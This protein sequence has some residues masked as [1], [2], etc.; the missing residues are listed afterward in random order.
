VRLLVSGSTAIVRRLAPRWPGVLGHLLTPAN[1]NSVASLLATGLPWGADNGAFGGFDPVRFRRFLRRIR[2]QPR[3]LW[4]VAPDAV[5][6]ARRTLALWREWRDEVRAAGQPVAFVGQDGAEDL[7][8]PWGEFDAWFVGGSTRW[9]LSQAAADL[10]GQAGRRGKWVHMGRCNSRR[11]L[12]AA[13]D[14][15]CDSVDGSSISMF[16]DKYIHQFCLWARQLGEQKTFWGEHGHSGG[17]CRG[18]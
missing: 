17:G 13:Y 15:G 9:K 10:D 2:G 6:D 1:R 3:C 14:R 5:G 11:R 7:D 16:G 12:R 4:V 8:I 18:R